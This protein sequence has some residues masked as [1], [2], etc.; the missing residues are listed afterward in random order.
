M[1]IGIRFK[2]ESG[3]MT[4]IA[5]YES[6]VL[7]TINSYVF[8]EACQVISGSIVEC[9]DSY[10]ELYKFIPMDDLDC[11]L[12]IKSKL[13]KLSYNIEEYDTRE[14][15]D[16]WTKFDDD[17]ANSLNL[18]S[19]CKVSEI[20]YYIYDEGS[21]LRNL[22]HEDSIPVIVLEKDEEWYEQHK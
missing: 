6:S 4:P 21:K 9:A 13:D 2:H 8:I 5:F 15:D 19:Y 18:Y 11:L 17:F 7:P 10:E 20:Y 3:Y 14:I 16:K 22:D 1:E 12:E